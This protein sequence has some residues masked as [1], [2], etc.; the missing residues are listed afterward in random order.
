MVRNHHKVKL[1]KLL[2]FFMLLKEEEKR[3][4]GHC[5]V[6]VLYGKT[7]SCSQLDTFQ[8]GYSTAAIQQLKH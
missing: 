8:G 2:S 5:F 1:I 7:I 4:N 3:Q 6:P